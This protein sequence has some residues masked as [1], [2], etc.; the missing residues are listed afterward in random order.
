[1]MLLLLLLLAFLTDGFAQ[2]GKYVWFIDRVEGNWGYQDANGVEVTIALTEASPYFV[3]SS[4]GRL[5]CR[6]TK[7]TVCKLFYRPEGSPKTLGPGVALEL[8]QLQIGKYLPLDTLDSPIGLTRARIDT[9]QDRTAPQNHLGGKGISG[10]GGNFPLIV[11]ACGE[12]IDPAKFTVQW[13]SSGVPP[14]IVT[15]IL[16]R[17]DRIDFSRANIDAAKGTYTS[18]YFLRLQDQETD[19]DFKLTFEDAGMST[20]IVIHVPAVTHMGRILQQQSSTA[21]DELNPTI[22]LM[23][24]ALKEGMWTPAARIASQLL[25]E[26]INTTLVKEYALLGTCNSNLA[27]QKRQ[28]Y[29]ELPRDIADKR[30]P[31]YLQTNQMSL[32]PTNNQ[33]RPPR[34][35]IALI[36]GNATY[37]ELPTLS[38]V[39]M[40]TDEMKKALEARGFEVVRREDLTDMQAFKDALDELAKAHPMDAAE[41]L[42]VYYSGH[43]ME[44]DGRVQML[45]TGA[46]ANPAAQTLRQYAMDLENFIK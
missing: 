40:D 25:Q 14:G 15:I 26:T 11:P 32:Q 23:D 5:K 29:D 45:G 17:M 22:G 18:D 10:C 38:S 44:F 30:C 43:G 21:R 34:A 35:G 28:L 20:A 16:Q 33:P 12:T 46:P 42:V 24:L 6:E 7:L 9:A 19:V 27:D 39:K 41:T 31:D 37:Q 4:D 13:P 1:M 2:R 36:I 8:P 3:I